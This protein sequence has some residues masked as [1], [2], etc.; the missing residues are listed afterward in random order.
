M[1]EKQFRW[2]IEKNE[3]LKQNRD[4]GFEDVLIALE[5]EKLIAKIEHPNKTKYPNQ[6]IFIVEIRDYAYLIPFVENETEIFLKT[7]IPNR[8]M[9]KKYLKNQ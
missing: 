5:Q 8:E 1:L 7:I 6:Q 2:N 4:I 9:T 3:W